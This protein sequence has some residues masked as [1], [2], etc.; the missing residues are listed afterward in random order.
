MTDT[1]EVIESDL[2][3]PGI[4][5]LTTTRRG[6]VSRAPFNSL[7]LGDHVGDGLRAVRRNRA[8][9]REHLGIPE[10]CWL[11]QVHGTHVVRAGRQDV[12][13]A[14]AQWTDAPGRPLAILSADCLPVV[15]AAQ[16]GS[17]IGVAH[18]G[19]RGLAAGVIEALMA[20]MPVSGGSLSAWMGPAISAGRYRV[21][22]EVREQFLA[23]Q[24][25]EAA[26]GFTPIS[27]ASGFWMANL[28]QLARAILEREGVQSVSGGALCTAGDAGRFYSHRRDGAESGRMATLAWLI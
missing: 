27:D 6:G 21:G 11:R 12:P 23:H 3:I 2:A 16:D 28:S 13:E 20:A 8:L 25:Q 1:L 26:A 15:L 24:G 10:P 22:S 4:R 9:I 17:C 18:A 7:N 19:W 5:A 14:D